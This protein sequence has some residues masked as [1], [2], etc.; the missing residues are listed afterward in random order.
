MDNE[1]SEDKISLDKNKASPEGTDTQGDATNENLKSDATSTTPNRNTSESAGEGF[2]NSIR[3]YGLTRPKD[4][5]FGGVCAGVS[6]KFKM[7]ITLVRFLFVLTAIFTGIGFLAYATAWAL[8][9]EKDTGKIHLQEAIRGNFDG[10]LIGIFFFTLFGLNNDNN[11]FDNF[12]S[13]L[14]IGFVFLIIYLFT[15]DSKY[16]ENKN[17]TQPNSNSSN[18]H[19][20]QMKPVKKKKGRK[21]FKIIMAF[22]ISFL[23]VIMILILTPLKF[24]HVFDGSTDAKITVTEYSEAEDG[25]SFN[26]GKVVLDFSKVDISE[27]EEKIPVDLKVGELTIIIP[28][29]KNVE[30]LTS[31]NVGEVSWDVNNR[32]GKVSGITVK[33]NFK[34]N[35]S[36]ISDK[37]IIDAK[38]R[39]GSI[40]I[41]EK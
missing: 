15:S 35:E 31:V 27:F 38:M 40:E 20:N 8:L 41:I 23:F 39:V 12:S 29:E 1:K 14:V 21:V 28:Q 26:S 3:E 24:T 32:D 13:L 22:L 25:Y 4:R 19:A 5:F 7:D 30:V 16:E 10:A 36:S 17:Q 6:E 9:P 34:T 37:L 2:F 11:L 33:E 18:V